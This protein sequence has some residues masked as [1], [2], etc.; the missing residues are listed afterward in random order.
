MEHLLA[1]TDCS[2]ARA[3]FE[4]A[5]LEDF[6][7]DEAAA[8]PLYETSLSVGLDV[9]REN[10]ARIQLASS[11]RNVGRPA[12][13]MH[14]LQ[15]FEF[16]NEYISARDAFVALILR[17]IGDTATALRS[18]LQAATPATGKYCRAIGAYA[19]ELSIRTEEN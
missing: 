15:G 3:L 7:S 4:R 11:L 17:D 8:V 18:A 10:Q 16:A 12:D 6:L 13:A 5:S 2:D 9:D 1:A 19:A 14:V